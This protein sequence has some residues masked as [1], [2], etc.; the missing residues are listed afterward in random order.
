MRFNQH[1]FGL[2]ALAVVA[3]KAAPQ[4]E[5]FPR[6]STPTKAVAPRQ[7]PAGFNLD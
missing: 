7:A 5:V 2:T 6:K 3:C 4:L 1:L